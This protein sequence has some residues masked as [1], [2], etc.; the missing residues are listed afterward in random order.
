[1]S[2]TLY[3]DRYQASE[4][5]PEQLKDHYY[6]QLTQDRKRLVLGGLEQGSKPNGGWLDVTQIDRDFPKRYFVQY[7]DF[8]TLV[9]GSLVQEDKLPAGRWKEVKRTRKLFH[10][11]VVSDPY[12]LV[13]TPNVPFN[14]VQQF[15]SQDSFNINRVVPLLNILYPNAL[16]D[17]VNDMALGPLIS[18]IPYLFKGNFAQLGSD[19][20]K[21]IPFG[22]QANFGLS[23]PGGSD[24]TGGAGPWTI[25]AGYRAIGTYLYGLIYLE[26]AT[27]S[28]VLGILNAQ[29]EVQEYIVLENIAIKSTSDGGGILL[30][31]IDFG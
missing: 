19:P 31:P 2:Y 26:D 10:R 3:T 29:H 27:Y 1:M 7:T 18:Y 22:S 21:L 14:T 13:F 5:D 16:R 25:S 24:A 4:I 12:N 23:F 20:T 9:P 11:V 28:F 30:N 8:N 6:V 15:T 17:P